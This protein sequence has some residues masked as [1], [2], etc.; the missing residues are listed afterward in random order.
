MP[1]PSAS[2]GGVVCVNVTARRPLAVIVTS[3]LAL[4][5]GGTWFVNEFGSSG[6]AVAVDDGE[7]P[8]LDARV[9]RLDLR[10][11][12]LHVAELAL[13]RQGEG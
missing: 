9:A 10:E 2:P 11:H 5:P 13:H 8:V 6:V 3:R 7:L 12:R 4:P 1:T